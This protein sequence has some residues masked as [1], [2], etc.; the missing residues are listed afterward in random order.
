[1]TIRIPFN[2][3][4]LVG[5]EFAY[6]QDAVQ[7]LTISEGGPYTRRCEELLRQVLGAPEVL[8]TSSCT[9]ALEMSALLL[10]LSPGDEVIMPSFTFTST[11]NA[12]VMFGA[13]PVF[14]DIRPDTLNLDERRLP[15]LITERTRAIV[16]V[17]Y[18]GVGCH[19]E[20]ILDLARRGGIT[21]VEDNAHGLLGSQNGVP[22][23]RFGTMATQSFH[24]TKNITCGKGG[25]LV[26]N[27]PELTDRAHHIREKGTNRREFMA[28]SASRY[29]WV[30]VG[31][32]YLPPDLLSAFLLGQL[33]ARDTI[34]ARRREIWTR[35]HNELGEW[36]AANNVRRPVVP[37]GNEQ[38]YHMYYLLLP[39]A[40]DRTRFLDFLAERGILAVFH[41]VPLHSSP[42]GRRLGTSDADCPVTEDISR[43]IVRLPFFT[44]LSRE[45][46][47]EVI[48]AVREFEADGSALVV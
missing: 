18:A 14:G 20:P 44:G 46:Q 2:R 10:E 7:G 17:H 4:Y 25:A 45:A 30:D 36:A 32:S 47:A 24:E 43:R 39:T 13:R 6:M 33:E 26:L 48:R 9:H 38:A 11:A 34:Q 37:E 23:G 5:T 27:D 35:Y 31:S 19:M 15:D 1:M 29:T 22:L 8:L 42:M 28:G 12:F 16:V 41:Y 40:A 21:V 3:P